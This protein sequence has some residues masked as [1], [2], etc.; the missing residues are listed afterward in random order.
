MA[1]V[2]SLDLETYSSVSLSDSGVYRYS[3]SPDFEIQLLSASY[4]GGPVECYQLA[5]GDTLP[6]QLIKDLTDP[7]ITKEAHNAQF[8]RVCLSRYLYG[9]DKEKFLDPDQ[10]VCTMAH[11]SSMGLPASLDQA[12]KAVGLAAD[13]Q[14]MK[15]GKALIKFFAQ[16]H[17]SKKRGVYKNEPSDDW[18]RWNL[19]TKYNEQDVKTELALEAKL[20]ETKIPEY[21]IEHEIYALDQRINDNGVLLDLSIIEPIHD[22]YAKYQEDNKEAAIKLTGME[23]PNS[24]AQ[25]KVWLAEQG[26]DIPNTQED[27]LLELRESTDNPQVIE[28]L[29]LYMEMNKSSLAKYNKMLDCVCQD[30]R[31]RGTLRYYGARTGR[32]AGRMVQFQNMP[33]MHLDDDEVD[34]CKTLIQRRDFNSL[35]VCYDSVPDTLKQLIRTAIIAPEGKTLVVCDYSAIEAR[36]IA[37]IA[38]QEWRQ[39]AFRDGK[40]IYC[41]SASM[42]YGVP[43]EKHGQNAHL[44]Q[45]GKI[46]ELALGYQGWIGAMKRMGGEAAGLSDAEMKDII[47]KWRAASPKIPE[48]WAHMEHCAELAIGGRLHAQVPGTNIRF[49]KRNDTVFVQLPSG[50]S[51]AYKGMRMAKTAKKT[52]FWYTE[53]KSNGM[54]RKDT[55]GGMLTENI[56]QAIARDCL[57]WAMLRLERAGY[58]II[59][60]VHD[61][62][63]IEC[64][65]ATAKDD[66][67][68]IRRIMSEPLPWAPGLI[69]TAE[70]FISKHY[71]KD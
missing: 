51:I 7:T 67:E 49:F 4:D 46:A 22:W 26:E 21:K 25:I 71:K 55:Y 12:G 45:K 59:F 13:D 18:D 15:E 19:Y 10:W 30:G 50:R 36:V 16:P 31:A 39:E 58:K 17:T 68:D 33:R 44:R 9:K 1:R 64:D 66:Y 35:L 28:F 24:R 32:W 70:G 43:V 8:E 54:T 27:T 29:D 42:I 57:A 40:D 38:G 37:W 34:L 3:E 11:A 53:P 14:K 2:L 20:N 56:T 6:D 52:T 41:E 62:V 61:E 47:L 69:L 60:H 65:E 63:I 23:N 5:A 48:L